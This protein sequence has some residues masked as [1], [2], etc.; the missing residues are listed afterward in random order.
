MCLEMPASRAETS[1]VPVSVERYG[2]TIIFRLL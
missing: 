2:P 1:E